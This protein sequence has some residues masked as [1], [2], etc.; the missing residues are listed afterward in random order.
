MPNIALLTLT[1][2]AAAALS[3]NRGVTT[4]GAVPAAGA[5]IAGI[6]RTSAAASGDLVPVDALG[7]T[8]AESGAAIAVGAR[9]EVDNVGRVITL[10]AGVCVG[11][12]APGQAAAGAAGQFVE[13]VLIP[14]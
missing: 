8:I 12:M 5:N 14:N 10:D 1:V 11:A 13:I 6:T 9:L 7:T 3:A 2:T 4:A